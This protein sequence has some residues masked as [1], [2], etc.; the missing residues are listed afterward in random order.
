MSVWASYPRDYRAREVDAIVAAARAGECVSVVGLSGAGKSNLLG[1]VAHTQATPSH[2]FVLVDGNRLPE[3]TPSAY[4]HEVCRALGASPGSEAAPA[5]EKLEALLAKRLS[6]PESSLTLLLDR[7]D[8]LA[9]SRPLAGMLRALR[10]AHKYQLTFVTATRRPL[11][12]DTEVAEL[13]YAHTVW[14]GVLAEGDA[15][16]NV[17]RFAERGRLRWDKKVA[18]RLIAASGGYPSFLR[19][20]CEA[21]AE[22]AGLEIENLASHPAVQRRLEEFFSDRP[23]DDELRRSGLEGVPLLKAR[24]QPGSAPAANLTAKE[25]RLL[26]TF[27]AHPGVVCEKDDLIRAVWPEDKVFERGVRDDSLAQLVRRLREKIEADPAN[28][29]HIQ[30]APGRGYT[31]KP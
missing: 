31:Y 26:S 7:F 29:R 4:L 18:D 13:F 11:P 22:G 30:T 10:D 20:A 16:W 9:D 17:D 2:P 14:L 3:H 25:A 5:A 27:Q 21:H 24:R 8:V 12:P 15:R 6:P 19:A 23:G 28:P 1:F